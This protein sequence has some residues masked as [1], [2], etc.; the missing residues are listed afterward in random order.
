MKY[1]RQI[2]TGA[3]AFSLLIGGSSSAMA[4]TLQDQGI[5]NVFTQKQ[6]KDYKN[7]KKTKTISTVSDMVGTV[8]AL[9]NDG[10]TIE[11]KNIKDGASSFDV[12]TNDSTVFSKRGKKALFT[13]LVLGQKVIVF[14][15]LDGSDNILTAKKVKI[16]VKS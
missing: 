12:H 9:S 1:K 14:G 7:V 11:T 6:V 4:L 16:F 3:L 5:K 10:F 13:N 15:S 8:S 2:A